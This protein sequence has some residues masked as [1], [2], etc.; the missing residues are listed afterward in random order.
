M[1]KD[2]MK[3]N[4]ANRQRGRRKEDKALHLLR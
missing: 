1:Q 2:G 3:K 4:E